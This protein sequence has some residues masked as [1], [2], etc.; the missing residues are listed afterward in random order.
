MLTNYHTHH[1]RC[2]HAEGTIEDYILEAIKEGFSEIGIACHVPYENFPEVGTNQRME[3]EELAIYFAEIDEL[4]E[5]YKS[6][7]KVLK[8]VE[9]EYFP[10]IHDYVLWLDTQTD[11]LVLAGHFIEIDEATR[12]YKDAFSFTEPWQLERYGKQLEQAMATRLFA[13]VA[14]PDLFMIMYPHWDEYC[15]QVVHRLAQASLKYDV[16]LEFNTNGL[17]RQNKPYPCIEF[18]KIVAEQYPAVKVVVNSDCHVPVH[19]NDDVTKQA[20]QMAEELGLNVL[21]KLEL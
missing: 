5:K 12:Q 6:Q 19:L 10:C 18:W 9:G 21:T 16:P 2:K 3:F 15:D 14:H 17:R 7:I 8:S 13:F 11:Y 20:R 1:Y 4:K